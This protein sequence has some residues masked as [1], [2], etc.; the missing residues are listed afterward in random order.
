MT[1]HPW[2]QRQEHTFDNTEFLANLQSVNDRLGDG[3]PV[4]PPTAQRIPPGGDHGNIPLTTASETVVSPQPDPVP[5]PPQTN[6]NAQDIL[7]G[8]CPM[9]PMQCCIIWAARKEKEISPLALKVYFASHE[10]KYWR[11]QVEPGEMYHY[12][13]YGFQPS[14]V[15]R[16]LPSVSAAQRS[17]AFDELA[18]T[19]ILTVS[20][21]G[22]W[23][24]ESLDDVTLSERVTHRAQAMFSQLH[25]DTRD[26]IVKIPR[27]LLKLLVQCGRRIVRVA[28]LLGMLLTTM[29]TKRTDRYGGYKGCCK[30][31]WIAKLFG[32]NVKRV[33]L[34]R[35]QLIAEGWFHRLPTPQRVR[36]RWGEWVALNPARS[37]SAEPVE[38]FTSDASEVQP[39]QPDGALEVQPPL[40]EPVPPTELGK[41]QGLSRTRED[42]GASQQH[43]LEEPT[44]T[45]IKLRDLRDDA[46]SETLRQEVIRR[47]YVKDTQPQR[48]NFFAAIAHALRGAKKNACG[49]LR[50]IV[51]KGLWDFLTE[52]DEYMALRRLRQAT[53]NEENQHAHRVYDAFFPMAPEVQVQVEDE[54]RENALSEDAI[55]VQVYTR[56]FERT[57]MGDGTL[58]GIQE[59]GYLLDWTVER[60][61]RAQMEVVMERVRKRRRLMD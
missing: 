40:T 60:W 32:V 57:H 56:S 49:L 5:P 23:F 50:T 31:E 25:Q 22:V 38:N 13:P 52:A 30:A 15:G 1:E 29:L 59:H 9:L 14:D 35:A 16:L 46:R 53:K 34:E 51:E 26:K 12:E 11:S 21:N 27:R 41:N 36:N 58:Q 6:R 20:E 24:A 39:L 55:T 18:A 48:I 8:S 7:G 54:E 4:R 28:T 37:G 42:T 3:S 17:R 33:N 10:V 45:D 47:G 2:R 44:W 43:Q 19:T 61:E